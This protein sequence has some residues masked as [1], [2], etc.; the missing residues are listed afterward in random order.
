M[1]WV[2]DNPEFF[3]EFVAKSV[4]EGKVGTPELL[5]QVEGG[6]LFD[7]EIFALLTEAEQIS[8]TEIATCKFYE[9]FDEFRAF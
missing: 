7:Y 6:E 5:R 2:A 3:D 9:R 4:M 1:S 8:I